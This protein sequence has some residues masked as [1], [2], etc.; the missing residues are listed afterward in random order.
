MTIEQRS[1]LEVNREALRLLYEELGLTDAIRFIR[2]FTTGLGNYVE[3]RDAL[4]GDK[5]LD[6]I[7][8]EIEQDRF[9]R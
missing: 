2:Q 9:G 7:L 6:E 1:L 3:E 8:Q 4:F 5:T